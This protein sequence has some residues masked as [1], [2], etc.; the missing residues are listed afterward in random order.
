LKKNDY[1]VLLHKTNENT[2]QGATKDKN[3]PS[4]RKGSGYATSDVR[5]SETLLESW[6]HGFDTDDEQVW[7]AE[8]G[9]YRFIKRK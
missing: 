6:N 7:G 2:F 3:C 1:S 4:E 9:A 8:L 5:I